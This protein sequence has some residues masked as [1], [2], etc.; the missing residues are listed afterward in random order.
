[1]KKNIKYRQTAQHFV[2]DETIF[3][4]CDTALCDALAGSLPYLDVFIF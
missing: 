2:G 1:M 4:N 3:F